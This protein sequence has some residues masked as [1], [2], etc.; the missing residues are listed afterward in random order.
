MSEDFV[1]NILNKPLPPRKYFAQAQKKDLI[2]LHF[3][4]S[5]DWKVAY[6]TF[7]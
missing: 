3:T 1:S 4:A 5:Y 2:V 7:M 6:K